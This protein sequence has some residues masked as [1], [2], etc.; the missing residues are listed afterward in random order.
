[1]QMLDADPLARISGSSNSDLS[2]HP[3]ASSQDHCVFTP[4]SCRLSF[5]AGLPQRI[6][7]SNRGHQGGSA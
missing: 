1:M 6:T 2:Q 4:A 7:A 5:A 3:T